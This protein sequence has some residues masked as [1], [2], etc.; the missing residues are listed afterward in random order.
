V[1]KQDLI[2]RQLADVDT[3]EKNPAQV[4][5]ALAFDF[6][7][8]LPN[9]GVGMKLLR[10]GFYEDSPPKDV[11]ENGLPLPETRAKLRV[12]LLKRARA[13]GL[14]S[15]AS[16]EVLKLSSYYNNATL[17]MYDPFLMEDIELDEKI[18][19]LIAFDSLM[20]IAKAG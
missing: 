2:E 18:D 17:K 16:W 14:L 7:R 20:E 1:L 3:A 9:E 11:L 13:T 8:L 5:K 19:R 12:K 4:A 6:H 15:G 10:K